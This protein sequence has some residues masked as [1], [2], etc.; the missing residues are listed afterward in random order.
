MLAAEH[1]VCPVTSYRDPQESF[2]R[3]GDLSAERITYALR[4]IDLDTRRCALREL[5][6]LEI[7]R[8][9]DLRRDKLLVGIAV[10][11][12]CPH[13]TSKTETSVPPIDN[14]MNLRAVRSPEGESSIVTTKR[15]G[16]RIVAHRGARRL[17]ILLPDERLPCNPSRLL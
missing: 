14:R 16:G 17:K 12:G 15:V 13:G 7:I 10:D 4:E 5:L 3:I 2:N 11:F 6:S 9:R 8:R 1:R